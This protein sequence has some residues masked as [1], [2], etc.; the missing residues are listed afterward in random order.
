MI[1][2]HQFN[3][4]VEK[5]LNKHFDIEEWYF[6]KDFSFETLKNALVGSSDKSW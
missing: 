4:G 6:G 2:L 1:K 3:A 5:I